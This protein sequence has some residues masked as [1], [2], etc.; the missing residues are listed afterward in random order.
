MKGAQ[1][2]L[3]LVISTTISDYILE[4]TMCVY[5]H[6]LIKENNMEHV[7]CN[8]LGYYKNIEHMGTLLFLFPPL[9]INC[10]TIKLYRKL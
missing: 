8:T 9:K 2:G 10:Y 1:K 6:T 4:L 3:S 5:V 7:T